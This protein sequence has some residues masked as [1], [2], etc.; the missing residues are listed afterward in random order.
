M[1]E[2]MTLTTEELAQ[3]WGLSPRTLAFWRTEGTGPQFLRFGRLIRYRLCDVEAFEREQALTKP[4]EQ[5]SGPIEAIE[6]RQRRAK[7][8]K[9]LRRKLRESDSA[10]ADVEM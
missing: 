10:R 9:R 8:A 6:L 1:A 7:Q 2:P 5:R 3:R 4:G